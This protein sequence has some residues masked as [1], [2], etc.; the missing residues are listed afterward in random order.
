MNSTKNFQY[1][2]ASQKLGDLGVQLVGN[3]VTFGLVTFLVAAWLLTSPL[4]RLG[5]WLAARRRKK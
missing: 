5:D 1:S 4:V 2:D 3:A